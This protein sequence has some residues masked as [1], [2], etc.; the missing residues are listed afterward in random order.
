M[1]RCSKRAMEA[2]MGNKFQQ[3]LTAAVLCA[4]AGQSVAAG[5]AVIEHGAQG[6]GNSFSGGG[7]VAEDASTL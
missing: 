7:A 5:F 6:M 4:G 1:T 2:M 3:G